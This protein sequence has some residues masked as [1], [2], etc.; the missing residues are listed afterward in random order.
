MKD[1]LGLSDLVA[2]ARRVSHWNEG[3]QVRGRRGR[4]TRQREL[5]SRLSPLASN[6]PLDP[7]PLKTNPASPSPG[8]SISISDVKPRFNAIRLFAFLVYVH[9]VPVFV[10][11]PLG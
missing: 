6:K 9:G 7:L 5:L 3:F 10:I 2:Q 1:R 11:S 8:Y 4:A